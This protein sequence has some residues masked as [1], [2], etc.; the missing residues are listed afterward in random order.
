V[1][2]SFLYLDE[3]K[4]YQKS[5]KL[6]SVEQQITSKEKI[7]KKIRQALIFKQKAKYANIDLDSNVYIQPPQE[8]LILETFA[9]NLVGLKGQFVFCTN[10]FDCIDKLLTLLEQRKWKHLFCW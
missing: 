7:L 1:A 2:F 10:Q 8:E 3:I 5:Y 9:K 6:P 4:H